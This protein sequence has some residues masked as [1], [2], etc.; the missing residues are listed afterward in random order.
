MLEVWTCREEHIPGPKHGNAQ[1]EED[2]IF[3][4]VEPGVAGCGS[5]YPLCFVLAVF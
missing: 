5:G 4:V 3:D 1:E 2:A